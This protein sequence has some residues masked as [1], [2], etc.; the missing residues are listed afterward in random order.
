[1]CHCEHQNGVASI[2]GAV[3]NVTGQKCHFW[4]T[5]ALVLEVDGQY[6]PW[7][8]ARHVVNRYFTQTNTHQE[9]GICQETPFRTLGLPQMVI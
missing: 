9:M 5:T 2:T 1:M 6:S 3:L 7:V 8:A 4:L